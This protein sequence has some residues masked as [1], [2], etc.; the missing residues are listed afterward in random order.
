M[1][2]HG[3]DLNSCNDKVE[4]VVEAKVNAGFRMRSYTRKINQ[5]YAQ[6]SCLAVNKFYA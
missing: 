4:K 2:Q 6:S 5:Y 1:E 3:H